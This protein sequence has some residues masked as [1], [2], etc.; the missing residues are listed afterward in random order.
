MKPL[1]L[2]LT[3]ARLVDVFRLR[4][5]GGWCGIREGRFVY[6]EP[7]D[8]P[9]R[10]DT[11]A[12]RDLE[13]RC[14]APGLI[15]AHLHVESSLM[16][17]RG[18]AGAALP[19]GTTAVLADPHEVANV[20]GE[21]GVRWMLEATAG[22]P[23][24][25]YHAIPSSVPA[26]SAELEWTAERIDAEAVGRLA[27]EPSVLALGEV[28]DARTVREGDEGLRA[29]V[30]AAREAGLLVEFTTADGAMRAVSSERGL[31][32]RPDFRSSYRLPLANGRTHI[33]SFTRGAI[34]RRT[35]MGS[36]TVCQNCW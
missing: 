16:T 6:V 31:S 2:V 33:S 30:T 32:S 19:H 23:L 7:G 22:L 4:V 29:R 20:A 11:R 9:A 17:P 5:V 26:T 15:D 18:F 8:P 10:V 28:M 35:A 24:R 27:C 14:L 34:V 13:G 21:A 3:H 1:D 12:V 25:V 36:N